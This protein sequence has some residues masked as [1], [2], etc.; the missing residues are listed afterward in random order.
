MWLLAITVPLLAIAFLV[1]LGRWWLFIAVA[2]QQLATRLRGHPGPGD[3][4][5]AFAEVFEDPDL[6]VAYVE[7]DR[8]VDAG[9]KPDRAAGRR[10]RSRPDRGSR[11]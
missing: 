7:G 1:G 11:R 10:A 5:R 2:T 8:W 3:L 6:V 4:Q 9:G